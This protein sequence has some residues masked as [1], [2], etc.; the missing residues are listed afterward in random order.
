MFGAIRKGD[1]VVKTC[2]GRKSGPFYTA[3][4]TIF[5]EGRG[6]VRVGD[7]SV[8][9]I[10]LTGSKTVFVDGRPAATIKSIVS[11]G[12]IVSCSSTIFIA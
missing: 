5:I 7:K 2:P 8:P 9:G 10:C 4:N 3:S 12:R 6:Q 11:C 1:F